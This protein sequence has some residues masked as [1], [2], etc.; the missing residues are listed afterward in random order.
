M[1]RR[2]FGKKSQRPDPE[3]LAEALFAFIQADTWNESRRILEAHPELLTDEA[4]AR[5]GAPATPTEVAL[6]GPQACGRPAP[7]GEGRRRRRPTP[8]AKAPNKADFNRRAPTLTEV[9]L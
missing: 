8:G 1:F 5:R 2:L 7:I 4:D 3:Q 6:R 9:S